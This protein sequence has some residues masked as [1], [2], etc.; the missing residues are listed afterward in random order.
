MNAEQLMEALG[1]VDDVY[2][3]EAV[4][5]AKRPARPRVRWTAAAVAAVVVLIF[6]Q[7]APGAAALNAI[8]E[9]ASELFETMFPPEERPATVEGQTETALHE[10]AGQLPEAQVPGFAIYYDTERYQLTREGGAARIRPIAVLPSREELRESSAALLEGLSDEEA[11]AEIDALLAERRAAYDALPV[12]ELEI[13]HL[14][15]IAPQDAAM[16]AQKRAAE[17]WERV[18]EVTESVSPRGCAFSASSG[19]AWNA[20]R[21][22][23]CF[24]DDG[25]GGAFQLTVRWF[26]EAEEGHGARLL[27]MLDTFT[28]IAP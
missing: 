2:L 15:D 20:P 19:A 16:D 26:Q 22:R 9:A 23:C 27:Q 10:A 28:V 11:E 24:V 13:V 3:L 14:A 8:A 21:E 7:T 12:C 1:S 18:T 17:T 6:C 25:Q 5:S 4:P